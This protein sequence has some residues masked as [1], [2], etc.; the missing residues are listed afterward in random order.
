[1]QDYDTP[2]DE[3]M[4]TRRSQRRGT[5]G[6]SCWLARLTARDLVRSAHA[7][8]PHYLSIAAGSSTI[9]SNPY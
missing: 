3:H 6:P 2:L 9:M 8:I 4:S 1:M 5:Q 7:G